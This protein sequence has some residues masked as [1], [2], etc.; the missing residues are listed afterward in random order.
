MIQKPEIIESKDESLTF[1]Q[2]KM[3]PAW[4]VREASTRKLKKHLW[5]SI[6]KSNQ[7]QR[8]NVTI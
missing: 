3:E 7:A 8:V 1:E 5:E 4:G 6:C 2:N